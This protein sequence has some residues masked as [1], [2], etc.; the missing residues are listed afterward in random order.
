MHRVELKGIPHCF[1]IAKAD[2]SLMYRVELKEGNLQ[3]VRFHK[4]TIVPNAP[5]GVESR[6]CLGFPAQRKLFLMHR[7]KLKEK[8]E[9]SNDI[10]LLHEASIRE[11]SV[12]VGCGSIFWFRLCAKAQCR[13]SEQAGKSVCR[14]GSVC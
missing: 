10:I 11:F 6:T 7:V 3:V 2:L 1:F 8:L 4:E 13:R 14:E 12:G 5:C 9:L